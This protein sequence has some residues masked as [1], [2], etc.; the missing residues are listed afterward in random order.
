MTYDV[1]TRRVTKQD[2][3]VICDEKETI[4]VVDNGCD[5]SIVNLNCFVIGLHSGV[6]YN[7]GGALEGIHHSNLEVVNNACCVAILLNCSIVLKINQALLDPNP[8]QKE[9]LLQPHQAR[10]FGVVVND[11]AA[12]HTGPNGLPGEQ[13]FKVDEDT[14]PLYFDGWKCY[15]R[16]RKPTV[17]ELNTLPTVELTSSMPYHPHKH[18]QTRR[19]DVCKWRR[20]LGYPT[21]AVT[22]ATLC[23]TTQMVQTLQSES[24]DNMRDYYKT[25]TWALKSMRIDDVLYSD[26]FFSSV[27]SIRRYWCF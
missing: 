14:Y 18:R 19:V 21:L 6:F 4:S 20:Q 26:V 15:L 3:L 13:S 17:E 27:P 25:H 22:R 1:M 8:F 2:D 12:R 5:Q 7:L 11:V 16:I 23:N 9:A 24:R 10:S